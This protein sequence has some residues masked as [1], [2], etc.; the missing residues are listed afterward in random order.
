MNWIEELYTINFKD[1]YS[2][3]G[4][5]VYLKHILEN[6]GPNNQY[7]ID[8]GSGD[9][10]Y[11]SN[12]KFLTEC[13]W[14]GRLLDKQNGDFVTCENLL[15]LIPLVVAKHVQP[16]FVS[17]DIDGNDYWILERIF[18]NLQPKVIVAEFNAMYTDSRTI[19]YNSEHEWAGDSYYGFTFEAGCKL[20]QYWDYEVIF[21]NND[22][23]MYMVRRDLVNH[24]Y[25]KVSF[26]KNDFFKL[27]ERLDWVMI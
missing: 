21:Q 15:Q 14:S 9:G 27:S 19:K 13:G 23:N 1:Q 3:G 5:G 16:D 7:F 11:L 10:V 18:E 24:P 25:P 12:S 26:N 20:A 22:M 8:I 4:E 17:I 6:T 2:Q